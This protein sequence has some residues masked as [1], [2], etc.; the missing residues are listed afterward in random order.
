LAPEPSHRELRNVNPDFFPVPT[1]APFEIAPGQKQAGPSLALSITET[2]L[3]DLYN[4]CGRILHMRNP[5]STADATHQIG[6]TVDEWLA[7]PEGLT[8]W[9]PYQARQRCAVVREHARYWPRARRDSGADVAV[10]CIVPAV[11]IARRDGLVALK[12]LC[13]RVQKMKSAL[14][15]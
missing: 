4:I 10:Y 2:E 5:F 8:R 1:S 15:R 9:H 7:R 14:I 11:Y 13:T 6:Y 3:V 12:T